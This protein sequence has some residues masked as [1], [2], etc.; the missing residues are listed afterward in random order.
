M[1]NNY[2]RGSKKNDNNN[3]N[4]RNNNGFNKSGRNYGNNKSNLSIQK[5]VLCGKIFRIKAEVKYKEKAEDK[6]FH[7]FC[8]EDKNFFQIIY[9]LL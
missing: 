3:N 2:F 1:S 5:E 7:K 8:D 9:P 6:F 4:Y